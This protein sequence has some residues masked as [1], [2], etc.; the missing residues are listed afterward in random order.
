[1]KNSLTPAAIE[2]ARTDGDM[3]RYVGARTVLG[4]GTCGLSRCMG[5]ESMTLAALRHQHMWT[6]LLE[7][8]SE[9]RCI[10]LDVFLSFFLSLFDTDLYFKV[11]ILS[12][13]SFE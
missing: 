8:Q 2:P 12:G 10:F 13:M 4:R 7:V 5:P 9:S 6:I 3:R 1:M 11:S